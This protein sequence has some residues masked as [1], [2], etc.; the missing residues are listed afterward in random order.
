M[1]KRQYKKKIQ[2]LATIENYFGPVNYAK[3]SE[4]YDIYSKKLARNG[5]APIDE[6]LSEMAFRAQAQAFRNDGVKESK[7]MSEILSRSMYRHSV[8]QLNK[9]KEAMV[10]ANEQ[11]NT[12]FQ[13]KNNEEYLITSKGGAEDFFEFIKDKYYEFKEL[14]DFSEFENAQAYIAHTFFGSP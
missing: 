4:I 11:Y 7:I 8:S 2:N 6:K 14:G 10:H 5:L 12:N 3:Y 1:S 13:I 9:I